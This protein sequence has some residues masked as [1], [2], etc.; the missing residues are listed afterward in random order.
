MGRGACFTRSTLK[1]HAVRVS[2]SG[3][4]HSLAQLRLISV[5]SRLFNILDSL[6]M[7]FTPIIAQVMG[8]A[9]L[10]YSTH[11]AHHA[12]KVSLGHGQW[13]RTLAAAVCSLATGCV[14]LPPRALAKSKNRSDPT[15]NRQC[16]KCSNVLVIRTRKIV[17]DAGKQ[18]WGLLNLPQIPHRTNG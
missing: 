7:D 15:A 3:A 2:A 4:I 1:R 12:I 17:A 10:V 13:L 6:E 9:E 11:A 8:R 18:F 16:P 14:Y 5:L